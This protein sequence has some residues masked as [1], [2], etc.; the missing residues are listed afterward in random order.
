MK[1]RRRLTVKE[2]KAV[3]KKSAKGADEL[4]VKLERAHLQGLAR[5]RDLVLD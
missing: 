2:I 1:K 5:S 4:R 3:L